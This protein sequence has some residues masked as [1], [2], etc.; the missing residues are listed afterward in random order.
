MFELKEI[1]TTDPERYELIEALG[2]TNILDY[3]DGPIFYFGRNIN[4][5]I[6]LVQLYDHTE[7]GDLEKKWWYVHTVMSKEKFF[8]FIDGKISYLNLFKEEKSC[9]F[10]ENFTSK[11]N[12]YTF[13]NINYT[14]IPEDSLPATD[15]YFDEPWCHQIVCD[16][17]KAFVEGPLLLKDD[18]G[19][20]CDM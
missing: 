19:S 3:Y 7:H 5:E 4:D 15:S 10:E 16:E 17:I 8:E 18:F 6:V 12:V 11:P 2:D 13:Y 1:N 14:D 9:M 20:S